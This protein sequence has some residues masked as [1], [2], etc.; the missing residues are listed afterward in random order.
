MSTHIACSRG[1]LGLLLA[2]AAI[3]A[4]AIAFPASLQLASGEVDGGSLQMAAWLALSVA[5]A[6]Y[7]FG[8]VGTRRAQG[9]AMGVMGSLAYVLAVAGTLMLS[10]LA[11]LAVLQGLLIVVV[12]GAA[13]DAP[14][15]VSLVDSLSGVVLVATVAF[16]LGH[17]GFGIA[18]AHARVIALGPA[19]LL[20]VSGPLFAL[21]MLRP[22]VLSVV[23]AMG[24]AVAIVTM[25]AS[26]F[27]Q[28]LSLPPPRLEM[29]SM[30]EAMPSI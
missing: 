18:S 6:T 3:A 24:F 14:M 25:A 27:R 19:C 8:L 26:L 2:A 12:G 10:L 20:A 5:M 15:H 30:R 4:A 9:R 16:A 1:G 23:G 21:G 11:A 22:G 13:P 28:R 17:L 29:P 7:T